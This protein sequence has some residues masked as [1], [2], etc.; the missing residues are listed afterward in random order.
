MGVEKRSLRESGIMREIIRKK[1]TRF[2]NILYQFY[3]LNFIKLFF[4]DVVQNNPNIAE[5]GGRPSITNLEDF[6]KLFI[7]HIKDKKDDLEY[8]WQ[9][10]GPVGA[11]GVVVSFFKFY[12]NYKNF[13]NFLFS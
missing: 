12:S 2:I 6:A 7:Q 8:Y 5:Q 13:F 11:P 4:A 1:Y 9:E 3:C 10:V